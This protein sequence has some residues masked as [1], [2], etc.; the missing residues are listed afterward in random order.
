MRSHGYGFRWFESSDLDTFIA[1]M[2]ENLFKSYDERRFH[3]KFIEN[4]SHLDFIPIAVV[5]DKAT[6][7]P[8]GFN[9]FLPLTLR[10]GEDRFTAVQGCDGFV[11]QSHRG[12]GLFAKTIEF[13]AE[14][15]SLGGPELLMGFNVPASTAAA[16]RAGSLV[17]G[18][19]ND[20]VLKRRRRGRS[21]ARNGEKVFQVLPASLEEVHRTYENW[22]KT[23]SYVHTYRDQNYLNWRFVKDPIDM[24]Q[25]HLMKAEDRDLGYIITSKTQEGNSIK[26]TIDDY[27]VEGNDH[28]LLSKAVS[29]IAEQQD[30]LGSIQIRGFPNSELKRALAREGFQEK[31]EPLYSLILKGLGR[32]PTSNLG[33]AKRGVD[34]TRLDCWYLTDSDIL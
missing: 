20:S 32:N 30:N 27:V 9:S 4:P 1:G 29:R 12:R 25:F 22:A 14:K 6:G 3:W 15:F 8:V 21:M 10:I 33:L 28:R 17:V 26:L 34:L 13:M 19:L 31:T 7:E 16:V 23:V 5:E 11:S 24:H 2:K 18:T